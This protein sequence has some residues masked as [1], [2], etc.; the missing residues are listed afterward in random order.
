VTDWQ[1]GDVRVLV[2]DVR[3]R[4]AELPDASVHCV[5]TSPPYWGLRDY[6]VEPQVWGGELGC[7]HEWA[8]E[9]H[10]GDPT[11]GNEGSTLTG[12]TR[13][14]EAANRRRA[15]S[16]SCRQCGAWRGAFGLEPTPDLYVQHLVEILRGV[17]R[18]LRPDG[19]LWLNLGDSYAGN[20]S[21]ADDGG[22]EV[23]GKTLSRR[24]DNA[25][26]PRSD[27]RV[28]GLKP[29]DLVGI[30]WRVALALQADGWWLRSDII[31]AKPNPMPES[32]TDR[33]TTAHEHVFLLA[34][35]E[36]YFYDAEAV[37]E[38]VTGTA[39][40]RG[41]GVNPKAKWPAGWSA[42]EGRHDG[43][44]NGR[45]R[46]KQNE[47][48][49]AA[50]TEGRNLRSVWSVATQPYPE[51]HFAT[52]PEELARRC[53]A[54]GTSERGC[55]A[56]CGAPLARVVQRQRLLDGETPVMGAFARP[57]EPRRM[58]NGVGHGRYTTATATSGWEPTC[59]HRGMAEAMPAP[60]TVLDP[61]AGSGTTLAVARRLGRA[62]VGIELQEAYLPLI[63]RRVGREAHQL[64]LLEL[65]EDAPPVGPVCVRCGSSGPLRRYLTGLY[66]AA[67]CADALSEAQ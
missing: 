48:W 19:T 65:V 39:H 7:L 2:G 12:S 24:R 27:M 16:A 53:I 29:K 44:S 20:R 59:K 46:P 25:P 60:C 5:V 56:E 57:D 1:D 35:S 61:F 28:E 32:V 31:W 33:P 50:V 47:S 54:A 26:V 38:P 30:P 55:C 17:R 58:P 6:G 52:F 43:V 22:R 15:T 42:E 40:P 18:V 66:C 62:A 21:H 63:R 45:F 37:R 49:S 10:L 14:Q 36:R 67:G 9:L 51:A 13:N 23:T 41:N 34:R 8:G 11:R 4:L 3:A 64:A